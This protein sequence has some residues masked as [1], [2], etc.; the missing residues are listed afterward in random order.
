M[1]RFSELQEALRSVETNC[2]PERWSD[3][4][5]YTDK[6]KA[7]VASYDMSV[8]E[9]RLLFLLQNAVMKQERIVETARK[10][11][12]EIEQPELM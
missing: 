7:R 12:K 5:A 1:N 3:V 8:M 9:S 10:K 4:S 11:H 2:T 6:Q